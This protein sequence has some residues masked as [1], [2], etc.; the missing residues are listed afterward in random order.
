MKDWYGQLGIKVTTQVLR[1]RHARRPGPPAGGRGRARE[2]KA[3]YDIELWGWSGN[4]DPNAL[5]QIFRCDAIGVILGQPVLQP[6]VR[7]AVRRADARETDAERKTILAEMQNLIYDEAPYDILFYDANLDAYRTDKFAGWQNK[8]ANGTPFFTYGTLQYTLL[9]DATAAALAD[10]RRRR[11]EPG[12]SAAPDA[13]TE[14]RRRR[15]DRQPGGDSSRLFIGAAR[16]PG[17]DRARRWRD[18]PPPFG[19]RRRARTSS[20]AR[21]RRRD[22]RRR[23]V[24]R[25]PPR[26]V[27]AP[28]PDGR[29]DMP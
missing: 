13:G 17:R 8:P 26:A 25:G 10:R 6:G 3:D 29:P 20:E 18:L 24:A 21:R 2:Y 12:A 9:T 28:A 14:R 7:H 16:R 22:R 4:P 1:L 5:L 15:A 23:R 11:P 19:R 27:R